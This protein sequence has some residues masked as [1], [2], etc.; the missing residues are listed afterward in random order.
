[1]SA[2][3]SYSNESFGFPSAQVNSEM[4]ESDA[5]G[6]NAHIRRYIEQIQLQHEKEKSL[7]LSRLSETDEKLQQSEERNNKLESQNE[8]LLNQVLLKIIQGQ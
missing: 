4:P 7:L 6:Y 5:S 3:I 1:M 8:N 2:V